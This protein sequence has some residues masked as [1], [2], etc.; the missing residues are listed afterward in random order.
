VMM[1]PTPQT[2]RLPDR[3]RVVRHLANGGM[4]SVW[5]VEDRV[6]G[7]PVAVKV[8]ADQIVGDS[9][10]VARF[11]REARAA[12]R[13]SGHPNVATIYDVGEHDGVPFIVMELLEGGNV[14]TRIKEGVAHSQGLAWIAQAAAALDYAHAEGVV[15]RDIKPANL[16]LD[17][18]DRAAV[19]DFGIAQM[20]EDSS[21][22]DTG[23]VVGSAGYLAPE[24]VLGSPA[25][26]ASDRYALAVVAFELLTGRKPFRGESLSQALQHVESDPPASGLGLDVDA[27]LHRAM[28]KRPDERYATA[29]RFAD[30]L[31]YAVE[32][33]PITSPTQ[34]APALMDTT[35]VAPAIPSV[36]RPAPSSPHVPPTT[37]VHPAHG[38]RGRLIA[39]TTLVG[40]IAAAGIGVAVALDGGA[41]KSTAGPDRRSSTT[42]TTTTATTA[43]PQ[44][45][46]TAARNSPAGTQS[47]GELNDRGFVMLSTNPAGAIPLLEASVRGYEAQGD[48]TNRVTYGYA[49][50]NLGQAYAATGR[51][52]EAI[53]MFRRRLD[54]SPNDRPGVV[55]DAIAKAEAQLPRSDTAS[56]DDGAGAGKGRD[57]KNKKGD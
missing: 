46:T 29:L 34:V 43:A 53:E 18:N 24:R 27:V 21:L 17:R 11:Q 3:Y 7:R 26:D 19:A 28:A 12:A 44:T 30:E 9:I 1:P 25:I 42:S 2:I 39:A 56:E 47:P 5:L 4:A 31:T 50:Y 57:K 22:T 38:R 13:V 15:H 51:T 16:L 48:A 41:P 35:A 10:A 45:P 6:L 52:S 55:L 40:V 23:Q 32:T 8:L 33:R 20:A 14:G 49:L 36:P 54:V 37:A